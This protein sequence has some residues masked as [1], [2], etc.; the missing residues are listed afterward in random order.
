MK[1]AGLE[2]ITQMSTNLFGGGHHVGI[3]LAPGMKIKSVKTKFL[4]NFPIK[5]NLGGEGPFSSKC[6]LYSK[7]RFEIYDENGNLKYKSQEYPN[8]IT[9]RFLN[10]LAN[11][12]FS[13]VDDLRSYLVIGDS[14]S[15]K[16]EI[17]INSG[18][19]MGR[20]V[21]DSVNNRHTFVL[22][23]ANSLADP[24]FF[25]IGPSD[26]PNYDLVLTGGEYARVLSKIDNS[27]LEIDRALSATTNVA[28][29]LWNVQADLPVAD[30]VG[31]SNTDYDS[32]A[33]VYT[34]DSDTKS[35][36]FSKEK[37][38]DY[39]VT[40]SDPINF[41]S[42]ALVDT[43]PAGTDPTDANIYE[44]VR[45]LSGTPTTITVNPGEKIRIYH[46]LV[47]RVYKNFSNNTEV[48]NYDFYG[49]LV[50]T[51]TLPST[52]ELSVTGNTPTNIKHLFDRLLSPASDLFN[53]DPNAS[54]EVKALNYSGGTWT[55]S[56]THRKTFNSATLEN[57]VNDSFSRS[58][59]VLLT[60]TEFV[61]S[62][63]GLVFIFKKS[64]NEVFRMTVKFQPDEETNPTSQTKDNL[65]ELRLF[66][67][68]S[69][70]RRYA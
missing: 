49:R 68:T 67:A 70:Y 32:P 41:S 59:S 4:D 10:K 44:L 18:T 16:P 19:V 64:G 5:V 56:G 11:K 28:F 17:K 21:F 50:S 30:R 66:L 22:N 63:Q 62:F 14:A 47:V 33:A 45:D 9:N 58:R 48:G 35:Y 26:W 13:Q 31:S 53:G 34:F 52:V 12:L 65:N 69:W 46:T 20:Y 29:Q 42:F 25:S 1:D 38:I 60:G 43:D 40:G 3:S 6:D 23:P 15:P 39:T 7:V 24:R 51:N 57:Y 36:I 37:R 2:V 8:L 27:T 54:L 55:E 61:T